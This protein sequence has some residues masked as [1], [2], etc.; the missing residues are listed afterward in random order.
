[1]RAVAVGV[2]AGG[3]S[4]VATASRDGVAI[5]TAT[6]DAANA[7]AIGF[8]RAAA[9]LADVIKEALQGENADAICVG[10]AGA[11]REEVSGALTAALRE[12]FPDA[13]I[14]VCDDARIALRAAVPQGDGIVLVAGTGSIAYGEFGTA[15][16]RAGGYGYLLG[17]EGSGFAIGAASARLLMRT[18]DGRAPADA[19][20]A[21]IAD[22]LRARQANEVIERV[23]RSGHPVR[24]LAAL[25][26]IALESANDGERSANKI[27]QSAALDLGELIRSVVRSA[28][29][30]NH[31]LPIVFS[32]GL[33]A[34]NSL[35]TYLLET[36]LMNDYPFMRVHKDAP[37]PH[38]GALALAQGM[39]A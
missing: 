36:R 16:Y 35:L 28:N 3:T 26:R 23:Y 8:D 19:F 33:L 30:G 37:E 20:T 24:T 31:D 39:L 6:G 9:A 15:V 13:R 27:V 17:D 38:I 5:G 22:A 11:G 2:D 18:F 12:R 10:A 25:A 1:M 7:N 21:R 4:T 32:G 14:A 34:G 29:A